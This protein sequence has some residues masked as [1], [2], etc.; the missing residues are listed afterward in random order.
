M[1]LNCLNLTNASL[2]ISLASSRISTLEKPLKVKIT[3]T[4]FVWILSIHICS[5]VAT[6]L[7]FVASR[8]PSGAWPTPCTFSGAHHFGVGQRPSTL[9]SPW[10]A[11]AAPLSPI[12]SHL[13]TSSP[14]LLRFLSS[15]AQLKCIWCQTG[16]VISFSNFSNKVCISFPHTI[17]YFAGVSF[18]R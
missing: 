2:C 10:F 14:Y 17:Y 13:Y 4:L 3:S 12:R 9:P 8:P 11:T 18:S 16:S 1:S 6:N 15:F 7:S 5:W